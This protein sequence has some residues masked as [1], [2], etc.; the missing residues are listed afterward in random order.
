MKSVMEMVSSSVANGQRLQ[1]RCS[2]TLLR[3]CGACEPVMGIK[4]EW[5]LPSVASEVSGSNALLLHHGCLK[6]L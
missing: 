6:S 3:L 5:H 2:L 4:A 1:K